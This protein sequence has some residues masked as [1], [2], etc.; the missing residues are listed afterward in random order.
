MTVEEIRYYMGEAQLVGLAREKRE[1][2]AMA[3]AMSSLFKGD[4]LEKYFAA[5][6]K[7]INEPIVDNT[8]RENGVARSL[9]E[10]NKLSNLLN[11]VK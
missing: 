4:V 1:V 11:K 3:I 2:Q 10:L 7:V 9:R 5:I 6:D 8:K